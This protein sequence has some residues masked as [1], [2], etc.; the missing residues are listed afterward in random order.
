VIFLTLQN[1]IY[2]YKDDAIF[3]TN[4]VEDLLRITLPIY[5]KTRFQITNEL[6]IIGPKQRR[7]LT[8]YNSKFGF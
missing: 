1:H 5:L 6:K 2:G 7:K 3:D 8:P 4:I